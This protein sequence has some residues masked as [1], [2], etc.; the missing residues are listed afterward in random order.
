ME[1]EFERPSESSNKTLQ[2]EFDKIRDAKVHEILR[3]LKTLYVIINAYIQYKKYGEDADF[4]SAI[5]RINDSLN[6]EKESEKIFH[7]FAGKIESM[8]ITWDEF[9]KYY[10]K[11]MEMFSSPDYKPPEF[12]QDIYD[13]LLTLYFH[14][15][16]HYLQHNYLL[17]DLRIDVYLSKLMA[18]ALLLNNDLRN[19]G[20][21]Y[22]E[23]TK[24]TIKTQKDNAQKRSEHINKLLIHVNKKASWP[25]KYCEF[26]RIGY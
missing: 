22:L 13:H 14:Y 1:E 19:K 4:N 25:E 2:G 5:K 6:S 16:E 26:C 8:E 7:Y 23:R 24:I 15:S 18:H 17:W 20:T 3:L 21:R 12:S 11:I 9:S 10:E